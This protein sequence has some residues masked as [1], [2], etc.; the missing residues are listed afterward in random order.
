MVVFIGSLGRLGNQLFNYYYH[1]CRYG[2]EILLIQKRKRIPSFIHTQKLPLTF[3]RVLIKTRPVLGE[4][5]FDYYPKFSP[6]DLFSL[7]NVNQINRVALHFRGTDFYQWNPDSVVSYDYVERS[8]KYFQNKI[9]FTDFLIVTDDLQDDNLSFI[10]EQ[11]TIK[12]GLNVTL[13]S[14]SVESDFMALASSKHLIS[15]PS[16]FAFWACILG[17][18]SEIVYSRDWLESRKMVKDKFWM[19][20]EERGLQNVKVNWL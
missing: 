12:F 18:V 8:L 5:F 10:V 17:E 7:K 20:L 1:V 6:R 3:T 16:T 4:H 9:D 15:G 14:E 11:L 2:E 19:E 13:Q